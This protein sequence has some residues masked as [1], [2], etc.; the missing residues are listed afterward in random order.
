VG[1]LIAYQLFHIERRRVVETLL[2]LPEQERL[3]IQFLLFSGDLF[4]QYRS[5]RWSKHA[6]QTPQHSEWQDHLAIFGLLVVA[7]QQIRD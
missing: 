4:G 6:V 1:L 7:T 3:G 5:L 2:G